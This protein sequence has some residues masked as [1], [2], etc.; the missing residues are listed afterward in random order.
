MP[1]VFG[2][3]LAAVLWRGQAVSF[4]DADDYMAKAHELL[5]TGGYSREPFHTILPFFRVPLY[6]LFIALVWKFVPESILAIQVAQ[7]ALSVGTSYLLYLIG[8][9][10]FKEHRAALVGALVYA[11]NPLALYWLGDVQSEPLF[12][13]LMAGGLLFFSRMVV[14]ESASRWDAALAGVLFGLASLT[15]PTAWWVALALSMAVI[16]FRIDHRPWVRSKKRVLFLIACLVL[17]I[18][19]WTLSNVRKTGGFILLN[20]AG[21]YAFYVGNHPLNLGLYEGSDPRVQADILKS[22]LQFRLTR[23]KTEE[24]Q[25]THGYWSLPIQERERLWLHAGWE[26]LRAEPWATT[27][28]WGYKALDFWRLWLHPLAYPRAQVILSSLVLVP[29]YALA[30]WGALLIKRERSGRRFLLL[31]AVLCMAVTGIHMLTHTMLRFRLP[32]VEPYL[33]ILAGPGMLS[34]LATMRKAGHR[35]SACRINAP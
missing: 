17:T 16:V 31:F 28:L 4:G 11:F 8:R 35:V 14:A 27:R 18:A 33:S 20:D 7:V 15:R 2:V 12:T 30:S 10:V 13:F 29:L 5:T 1:L 19:P 24:W 21:G 26:N 3:G 6:P 9:L 34:L 22:E 25:R 32:Y 23:E